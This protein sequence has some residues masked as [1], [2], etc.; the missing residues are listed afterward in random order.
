MKTFSFAHR[1]P[2]AHPM[3]VLYVLMLNLESENSFLRLINKLKTT[4]ETILRC[5]LNKITTESQTHKLF[6]N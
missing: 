2:G 6:D 3:Y 1:P 4:I 5:D